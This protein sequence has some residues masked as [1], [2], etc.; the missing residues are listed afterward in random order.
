MYVYIQNNDLKAISI[1]CEY[2]VIY[3][4]FSPGHRLNFSKGFGNHL[5]LFADSYAWTCQ[6]DKNKFLAKH[7]H[8]LQLQFK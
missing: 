3:V 4:I 1:I 6:A 7:K 5:K 8:E 2:N